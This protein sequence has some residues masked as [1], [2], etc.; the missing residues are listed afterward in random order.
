VHTEFGHAWVPRARLASSSSLVSNLIILHLS[1]FQLSTRP[2]SVPLSHPLGLASHQSLS[3]IALPL[4][5]SEVSR[6]S[7]AMAHILTIVLST[8]LLYMLQFVLQKQSILRWPL[9]RSRTWSPVSLKYWESI[10][11]LYIL[12]SSPSAMVRG[13]IQSTNCAQFQYLHEECGV[14]RIKNL[15]KP[16]LRCG[17]ER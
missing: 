4:L 6:I 7:L 3:I 13:T 5:C 10:P 14:N 8:S 17:N 2:S 11:C 12:R 15:H 1:T 9:T 16:S